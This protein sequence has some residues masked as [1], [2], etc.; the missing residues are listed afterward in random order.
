MTIRDLQP[1]LVWEIFDEITAVPRPSKHEEKIIEYLV[2][3]ARKHSL[4][5]S[6]DDIGNVVIRKPATA[7]YESKPTVVLQSHMD[8]VCE[9]NSDTV[10]NFDTD[11][12][13]AHRLP[14]VLG[15]MWQ[16]CR[17]RRQRPSILVLRVSRRVYPPQQ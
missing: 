17:L 8:M 13:C 6:R 14:N 12:L 10:H 3:F 5:Y 16:M 15:S 7:G 2:D 4:D 1:K 11:P 9:K